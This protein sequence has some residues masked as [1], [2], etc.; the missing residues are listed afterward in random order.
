VCANFLNMQQQM[1]QSERLSLTV[2]IA[3][4]FASALPELEQLYRLMDPLRAEVPEERDILAEVRSLSKM[5]PMLQKDDASHALLTTAYELA[6]V[7]LSTVG[8]DF[9]MLSAAGAQGEALGV[10]DRGELAADVQHVE[11]LIPPA[12]DEQEKALL[13]AQNEERL[14]YLHPAEPSSDK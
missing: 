6:I 10:L 12:T 4:F 2:S 11:S 1:S 13:E 9:Q 3:A 7:I 14:K 8:R 5:V